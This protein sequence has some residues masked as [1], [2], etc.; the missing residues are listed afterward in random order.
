MYK[1]ILLVS[2]DELLQNT[3]AEVL[4]QGGYRAISTGN[5]RC[6]LERAGHCEMSIIGHTFSPGEQ[7]QF[8]DRVH[9]S[10]PGVC[11]LCLRFPMTHPQELLKLVRNCFA[12]AEQYDCM[13]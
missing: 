8:I 10:N 2:R 11:L 5:M 13:A 4:Q 1:T 12:G 9:E 3:G 7:D 6:A